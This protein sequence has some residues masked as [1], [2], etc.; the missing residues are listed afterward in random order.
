ML[1]GRGQPPGSLHLSRQP[2]KSRSST[3]AISFKWS[4]P[5]HAGIIQSIWQLLHNVRP[6]WPPLKPFSPCMAFCI[7][8]N[9]SPNVESW[10]VLAWLQVSPALSTCLLL[11]V[12]KISKVCRPRKMSTRCILGWLVFGSTFPSLDTT[13]HFFC[14]V[15]VKECHQKSFSMPGW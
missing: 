11:Q 3:L 7:R 5:L 13:I 15:G 9:D 12:G 1:L 10:Y 2:R 8:R 14:G 6:L 4:L